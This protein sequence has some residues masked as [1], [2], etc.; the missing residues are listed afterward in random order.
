VEAP[1]QLPSLPPPLNPALAISV[2]HRTT[3][4]V[5]V[6]PLGRSH[7]TCT[8]RPLSTRSSGADDELTTRVC[9]LADVKR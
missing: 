5:S 4:L 7:P 8:A 9:C 6:R 2:H 3:N 1:G